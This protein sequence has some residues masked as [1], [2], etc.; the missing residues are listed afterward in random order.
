MGRKYLMH[1]Q[2]GK[3]QYSKMAILE[4]TQTCHNQSEKE[5]EKDNYECNG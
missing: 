3:H 2:E 4:Q 1:E 5:K